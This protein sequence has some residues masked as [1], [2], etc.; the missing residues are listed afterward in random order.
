MIGTMKL[1]PPLVATLCAAALCALVAAV[2]WPGVRGEALAGAALLGVVAALAAL[3]VVTRDSAA[4]RA[5]SDSGALPVPDPQAVFDSLDT[6]IAVLTPDGRIVYIN[7]AP[8]EASGID[9]ES[10]RGKLVWETPFYDH[11]AASQAAV[12]AI[13]ER[14]ATGSRAVMDVTIPERGGGT[15]T[16]QAAASPVFDHEGRVRLVVGTGADV[17]ER[18]DAQRALERQQRLLEQAERMADL[19]SWA[20]DLASGELTVSSGLR[21]I[22]EWPE[23]A[24]PPG[25]EDF[26]AHV[27][28]A[29][30][31]ELRHRYDEC[32]RSGTASELVHAFIVADG[33]RKWLHTRTEIE[34]DDGGRVLRSFGTVQ[35]VTALQEARRALEDSEAALRKAQQVGGLGHWRLNLVDGVG[36]WSD[37]EFRLFG[38]AP[39]AFEPGIERYLELVHPDDRASVRNTLQ[40]A[41]AATQPGT[42]TFEH[43]RTLAGSE[44]VIEHHAEIEVDAQ[45]RCTA[46]FGVSRDITGQRHMEQ[47][48]RRTNVELERR[49][50]ERTRDL[51]AAREL[52]EQAS[53]AKSEFLAHVSHELRTPM[54]A[55]LGFT[56]LLLD[57]PLEPLS[58]GQRE[59]ATEVL[60]AGRHLM[61][62]I[63]EMLDL[64][65]I[66]SGRLTLATEAVE[67]G[68][69]IENCVSLVR[70]EAEARGQDVQIGAAACGGRRV[71]CDQ[72]RLRQVLLNLLS[73]AIKY[74][75]AQGRVRI[76]TVARGDHCRIEV[77]DEGVGIAADDLRRLFV[78]F[79]RF[80]PNAAE[81]EGS[82]IGLALSKRLV[83]AMQGRLGVETEAGRGS[84]FWVELPLAEVDQERSAG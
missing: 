75:R 60:E 15:R 65:R 37:E 63:N 56:Q 18:V 33:R 71:W 84:R 55:V 38:L 22:L 24:P 72:Q 61:S 49:I 42:V 82:G 12:R 77:A 28:A 58:E 41:M 3:A 80:G 13:V 81:V 62:L 7:R 51:V 46:I 45:G 8:R 26:Y 67:I 59:S 10:V 69:L 57:D 20:L 5:G 32:L 11:S 40:E 23:D 78:P 70:A 31:A 83:E 50:D 47:A 73:N 2:T 79:E 44:H 25:F 30:A 21:R 68:P 54:N 35:D 64:T 9:L 19:G 34:R 48:L 4:A 27:P 36:V 16:L 39:G 74:N 29:D 6:A 1:L 17:T 43:R 76:T 66:E 52:A 53:R 14:A